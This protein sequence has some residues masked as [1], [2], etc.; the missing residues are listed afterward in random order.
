[1][2]AQLP[3]IP[4]DIRMNAWIEARI[5]ET[6]PLRSQ[7]PST[8]DGDFEDRILFFFCDPRLLPWR[9]GPYG[10]Q[11]TAQWSNMVGYRQRMTSTHEQLTAEQVTSAMGQRA[12]EQTP[13]T[14]NPSTRHPQ[15]VNVTMRQGDREGK[16]RNRGHDIV[17]RSLSR[18]PQ[19]M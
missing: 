17:R 4:G 19:G 13:R 12:A 14:C 6:H 8:V 3:H 18:C 16:K 5:A 1:M 2:S 10:R 9:A 15:G 11:N 7:Q